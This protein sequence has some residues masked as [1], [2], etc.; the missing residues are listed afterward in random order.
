M[1]RVTRIVTHLHIIERFRRR[2]FGRMDVQ[3]TIDDP[4]AYAK[5]WTVSFGGS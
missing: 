2:A 3:I 1:T 5:L 4:K